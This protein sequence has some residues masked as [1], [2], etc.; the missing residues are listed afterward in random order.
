MR[1]SH[2]IEDLYPVSSSQ[3]S[4][5]AVPQSR[6]GGRGYAVEEAV[7]PLPERD[8]R[9]NELWLWLRHP[10]TD[11]K[12]EL[13]VQLGKRA[14]G[15]AKKAGELLR[16]SSPGAFGNV[17]ADR[18]RGRSHLARKPEQFGARES[19]R[20]LVHVSRQLNAVMPYVE[21]T[22]VMHAHRSNRICCGGES[23]RR[24]SSESADADHVPWPATDYRLLTTNFRLPTT[25]HR[26][27]TTDHRPAKGPQ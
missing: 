4:E 7:D 3:Y 18:D 19:T 10:Q 20:C 6:L 15:D 2:L 1:C 26:P 25:D 16:G 23:P 27:P 24:R 13:A 17:R 12:L 8:D 11:R 5:S 14:N 21:T 22:E 9:G